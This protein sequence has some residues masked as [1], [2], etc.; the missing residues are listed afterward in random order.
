MGILYISTMF[1]NEEANIEDR[2][3]LHLFTF[4]M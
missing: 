3:A 1:Y 4:T 2:I